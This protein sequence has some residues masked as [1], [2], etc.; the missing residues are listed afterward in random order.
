[1]K[2]AIVTSLFAKRDMKV[3]ASHKDQENKFRN[4]LDRTL[5]NIEV[6]KSE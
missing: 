3:N 6:P 1:M 5:N 2:I 4:K